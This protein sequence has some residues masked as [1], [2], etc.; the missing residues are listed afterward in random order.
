MSAAILSGKE[1]S[2]KILEELKKEVAFL[3]EKGITP[4]LAVIR[5]GDDPASI[6]YVNGK[7]KDAE[8][9]GIKSY[10]HILP[11]S[12]SQDKL[13]ALIDNLNSDVN[14]HGIL[15]QLPLPSHIEE[16]AIIERI[17]PDKDVDGFH[18]INVGKMVIGQDAFLP[19]TP[20]GIIKMLEYAGI[21]SKGKHTVIIGRSNIVGKPIANLMMQ[22]R[23]P[24]NSTV[25]VCH[26]ATP[27]VSDYTL[28]A[29]IL[30]VAAGRPCVV[31][32]DM[33]KPGAVVIDVGINRIE[34]KE[35]PR[36]YR[37]VGDVDYDSVSKKASWI[38]PVPG[39][40]GL[41]TRAM[42]MYNTVLA[43]KKANS[44]KE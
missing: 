34:D 16:Q 6:A 13:C 26:T 3:K 31:N 15:V 28:Q 11:A 36:G 38:T 2:Q 33:V 42:L 40:V 18:P 32:A 35:H 23:N 14:I 5:V 39:G 10:E 27:N 30:I 44:I 24:G 20:F 22:K 29:D 19:C 37:L 9:I 43:V 21:E 17:S 25:T 4:G 12:T 8:K 7:K 41:M 1:I